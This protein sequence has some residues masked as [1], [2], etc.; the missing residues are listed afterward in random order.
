MSF[1]QWFSRKRCG[2]IGL[3]I[4]SSAVKLLELSEQN[5]QFQV[6]SYAVE[7]LPQGAVVEKTITDVESVGEAIRRAVRRAGTKSKQAAVAVGG[8]AVI[9]KTITMP[10]GLSEEDIEAQI[11]LEADQYIPF[12]LEEVALDFEV[13]GP[14]EDNPELVE[15]LIAACRQ[16]TVDSRVGAVELGGLTPAVVDVEAFAMENAFGLLAAQLPP[17]AVDRAV[18]VVDVGATITTLHV[19][20]KLRSIYTR[21]QVFGGRQLT[22]E[23]MRRYG[24]DYEA[25]GRAK[26]DGSLPDDYLTEVLEPFKEAVVQQIN[27][28]LQFY[29]SSTSRP[30]PVTH[31]VLAGGCAAIP[32]LDERVEKD[33]ATPTSV[34]NPF[35][36]MSIAPKVDTRA[37]AEDAPAMMIACGLALRRFD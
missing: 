21:E 1:L 22:E 19:I 32:G 13:L 6:E 18:A 9:T 37:L 4:S 11:Q 7:P 24:L 17:D 5:D 3:D 36:A 8:S 10:A 25:A 30:E 33:L 2:L 23:I 12:P 27:R 34:A 16:E 35:A 15:V 14:R 31:V 26:K 29:F 28:A 20:H